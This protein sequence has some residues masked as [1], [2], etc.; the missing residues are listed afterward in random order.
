MKTASSAQPL[1]TSLQPSPDCRLRPIPLLLALLAFMMCVSTRGSDIT[2]IGGNGSYQTASNWNSNSVPTATDR[3]IFDDSATI[4]GYAVGL[5]APATVGD[6]LFSATSKGV[7][8]KLGTNTWTVN[9]SFVLDQ[10]AG[11]TALA[12]LRQ[13]GVLAVTNAG[14][15][16]VFKVGN[17]DTGGKGL[18]TIEQQAAG[19]LP[20]LRVD[21]FLV[22]ANSTFTFRGGTLTI[23]HGS[24]IDRGAATTFDVGVTAGQVPDWIMLGG[25]N[26]LTYTSTGTTRLGFATGSGANVTVSGNDTLWDVGGTQL[27]VGHNAGASLTITNGGHVTAKILRVGHNSS[28]ASNS[29]ITVTGSGSRLDADGGFTLGTVSR[30]NKMSVTDGGQAVVVNGFATVGGG[31]T[32]TGNVLRVDGAG[33]LFQVSDLLQIGAGG[34]AVSNRLEI[35][36]SGVV[37]SGSA[38]AASRVGRSAGD[39]DNRVLVDGSG[40]LWE[41][42][43]IGGLVVGNGDSRNTLTAQNGGEVRVIGG[44]LVVGAAPSAVG[45]AATVS[46]GSLAVTNATGTAALEVR[47]GAFTFDGG[48]VRADVLLATNVTGVFT[49]N[50]GALRVGS[51]IVSNGAVFTVGNGLGAATLDLGGGTHSFADGLSIS[52]NAALTGVGTIGGAVANFGTVSPGNSA[53]S[54]TFAGALTLTNGSVLAMEIGGRLAGE[55]DQITVTNGAFA[56]GGTLAVSL[57]N[58]FT[59]AN[60]DVFHLLDFASATSTSGGFGSVSLPSLSG[61]LSWDTSQLLV[62]GDLAVVPEPSALTLVVGGCC[63]LALWANRRRGRTTERH[64]SKEKES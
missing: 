14:G 3:A 11:A 21:R 49:F 61:G 46:G 22:T 39:T 64:G 34:G 29:V 56:A 2:W 24:T 55:Y 63:L 38:T 57:I 17:T 18:F 33:S 12:T 51:S 48:S 8:W 20:T 52:T 10:T 36:G 54:I 45:N 32:A 44:N 27:T 59:P 23:L 47:R 16:A 25:T 37:R 58:S 9:N 35:T 7:F 6:V 26:R 43:G 42:T 15:T 62:T 19:D 31:T 53:G 5:S 28:A 40:S 50:S 13:L 4:A 1:Q 41:I 30:D 60:G